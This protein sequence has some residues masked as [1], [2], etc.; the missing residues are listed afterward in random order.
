[1]RTLSIRRPAGEAGLRQNTYGTRRPHSSK[2]DE[3]VVLVEGYGPR[4]FTDLVAAYQVAARLR[5]EGH[6]VEVHPVHRPYQLALAL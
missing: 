2:P 1:M 4:F 6:V 5:A 3:Y